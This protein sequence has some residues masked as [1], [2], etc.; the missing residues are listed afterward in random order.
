MSSYYCS[1]LG[2]DGASL[3]RV[4]VVGVLRRGCVLQTLKRVEALNIPFL[5]P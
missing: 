5:S 3:T 2:E 1:N 4:L